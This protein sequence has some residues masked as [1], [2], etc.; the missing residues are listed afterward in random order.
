VN[1]V[2]LA[3]LQQAI[4]TLGQQLDRQRVSDAKVLAKLALMSHQPTT[5]SVQ[6]QKGTIKAW[7]T[8]CSGHM[9][10]LDHYEAGITLLRAIAL[11]EALKLAIDKLR[12]S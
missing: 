6:F 5:L 11:V 10:E 9:E 8:G 2:E 7:V 1:Q 3:S 4:N 12:Q